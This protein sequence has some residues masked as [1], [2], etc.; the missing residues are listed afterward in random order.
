MQDGVFM[1]DIVRDYAIS[2]CADVRSRHRK[3]L[4]A[5]V[6][7]PPEGGWL[8]ADFAGRANLTW[9]VA[10]HG[11]YHIRQAI[12]GNDAHDPLV[13]RLVLDVVYDGDRA[14]VPLGISCVVALGV[15]KM[16]EAAAVLEGQGRYLAAGCYHHAVAELLRDGHVS[17]PGSFDHEGM[18][19]SLVEAQRLFELADAVPELRQRANER[20]MS[21]LAMATQRAIQRGVEESAE[22]RKRLIARRKELSARL[23]KPPKTAREMMIRADAEHISIWFPFVFGV[24]ERG[25]ARQQYDELAVLIIKYASDRLQA[26]ST[27]ASSI[28]AA[29]KSCCEMFVAM[30]TAFFLAGNTQSKPCHE[31]LAAR[32]NCQQLLK[33]VEDF[34]MSWIGTDPNPWRFDA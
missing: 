22:L 20:E 30:V 13:S 26:V 24:P 9:Y 27:F 14:K 10:I 8:E 33:L 15:D 29:E 19:T 25:K 16:L 11:C 17:V 21:I 4:E 3:L 31:W 5:I 32:I 1:H 2:R 23:L 28:T 12:E 7:S 34:D 6:D 18:V